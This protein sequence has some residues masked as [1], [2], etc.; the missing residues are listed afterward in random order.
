VDRREI[1]GPT[2]ENLGGC[3]EGKEADLDRSATAKVDSQ[4]KFEVEVEMNERD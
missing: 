2:W 3:R 1:R 4:S